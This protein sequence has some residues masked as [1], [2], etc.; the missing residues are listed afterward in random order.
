MSPAAAGVSLRTSNRNF[1]GRSGTKDAQ[2]YLVSPE[3]AAIS[4]LTG[5]ITDPRTSAI[6]YPQVER[7]LRFLLD[8]SLFIFPKDAKAGDVYRGPNIGSPP[9]NDK[10]P[11]RL[12]GVVQIKVGDNITTDHIMP[13]GSRLRYRSNIPKYSEYVFRPIDRA[14]PQRAMKDKAK[15]KHSVIVAGESYGQGSSREHAAMCPMYLGVKAVVA[16]SVERIHAANLVNFGIVPLSFTDPADYDKIDQ[17][18][19]IELPDLKKRLEN[20]EAL[21][22]VDKTKDLEIT[23]THSLGRRQKDIIYAGGLLPYTVGQQG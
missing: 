21:I 10:M 4:A 20:D 22:L 17:R 14:F 23:L 16:K 6:D 1:E 12:R 15:G 2:V 11:E 9:V 7:P 18:D 3:V 13:A 19:E 5:E 8:D